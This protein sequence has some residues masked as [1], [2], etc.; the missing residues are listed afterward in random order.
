LCHTGLVWERTVD[1]RVLNFRL[2]GINNQ[3]FI[4][5]DRETGSWW[6][7][8]SGAAILGPLKGK[9]LARVFH[10]ELTFRAWAAEQPAGR[11]LHPAA[12]TAWQ[13]FS[14]NWEAHTAKA[15]VRVHA[16]LDRRLPP[17]EIILG[18]EL[19]GVAK[20]YPQHRVLAQAPLHDRLGGVPIVLL[21]GPDGTSVRGFATRLEGQELEFVRPV[22]DS[23]G[24]VMD[25]ATGSRWD[26]RGEAVSGPLR[27]RQLT[28]VYVLKDYWFDW[29]TYHPN[30]GVYSLGAGN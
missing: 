13:R 4:M 16:T 12:D 28:P 11:V 8:V 17:R 23:A 14:D 22:A 1:G 30:T 21:V 9:R 2:A 10:D 6:Q 20:A 25:A 7:Q 19:G 26:F 24:Q 3:N 29:M 18:L 5:Q 27:G 15:P